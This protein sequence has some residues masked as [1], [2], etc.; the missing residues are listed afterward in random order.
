MKSGKTFLNTLTLGCRLKAYIV[1]GISCYIV[2]LSVTAL[3]HNHTGHVHT[4]DTCTA[5]W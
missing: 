4:E 2:L 1:I 3:A 5:W